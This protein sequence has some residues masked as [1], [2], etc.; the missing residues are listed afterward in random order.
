MTLSTEAKI[1]AA[2][3]RRQQFEEYEEAMEYC[4]VNDC[5]AKKALQAQRWKSINVSGLQRRLSGEVTNGEEHAELHILTVSEEA[6]LAKWLAR[7]NKTIK[8]K[9][10][11]EQRQK[12]VEIL[13][14]RRAANKRGGRRHVALS[15]RAQA[16]LADQG[17]TLPS[18]DWFVRF[19]AVHEDIVVEKKQHRENLDR[20]KKHCEAVVENH[21][22]SPYGLKAEL[23]DSGVMD[24]DTEEID[25]DRIGWLDEAPNFIDYNS[26]KGGGQRKTAAGPGDACQTLIPENREC[27]TVNMVQ[28]SYWGVEGSAMD[29]ERSS[30]PDHNPTAL[31]RM[32][33]KP[34]TPG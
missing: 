32:H 3:R 27:I 10:R 33:V 6:Q 30:A 25:P 5:G 22:F 4:K 17:V 29:S 24:R 13:Q 34:T 31:P 8:G 12:I 11:D 15:E 9:N 26:E 23:L 7:E 21:F 20:G 18:D 16:V 19:F 1:C 28:I 2:R 14:L